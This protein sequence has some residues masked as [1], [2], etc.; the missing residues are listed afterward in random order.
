MTLHKKD[1][2]DKELLANLPNTEFLKK[3]VLENETEE[4]RVGINLIYAIK[5][6]ITDTNDNIPFRYYHF[7]RLVKWAVREYNNYLK[8][9]WGVK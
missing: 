5:K 9:K 1:L 3:F 8:K 4:E 7:T 6:W 2:T